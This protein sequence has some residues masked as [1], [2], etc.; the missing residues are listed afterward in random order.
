ME[1]EEFR[2]MFK[3]LMAANSP[4]TAI[5]EL[6]NKAVASGAI[7]LAGEPKDSYRLAKIV[8]YAIL[9]EMCEQWRPLNGQ[10]RKEAENLRLFL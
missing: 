1:P 3:S 6:Y 9:C 4:L 5:E 7:Y 8:Y 2:I 10:N